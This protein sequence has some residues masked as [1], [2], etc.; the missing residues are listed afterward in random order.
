MWLFLVEV[1]D[2]VTVGFLILQRTLLAS[3]SSLWK[4]LGQ[5]KNYSCP[6]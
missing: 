6:H 2:R 3:H 5:K 4:S 1:A